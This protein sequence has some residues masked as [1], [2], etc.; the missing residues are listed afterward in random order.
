MSLKPLRGL[1]LTPLALLGGCHLVL[2]DPSGDVARQQS[3]IMVITTIIIALIIVPVLVAIGVVAWRY[4]A[5]NK[6]AKYDPN[7]DHSPQLELWV[8]AGPLLIIIAVGAVSWLG[9]HQTD[10]YR[11]LDRIA[12]G[13]PVPAG[14][15]PLEVDVVSLRWK[16][17]FLYPQYGIATVNELAAPVDRPIQFKLTADTMM[18]SFFVPA[19]VGQVYTMPGMQTILHGVINTPGEYKG[20]SANFSGAGFTDM[21]FKFHG[22]TAQDFDAWVGKVRAA[23]GD[24][25]LAAY[26]TLRKPTRNAPVQYFAK[27][28][29]DLYQRVLN[30]CAEPARVCK[31]QVMTAGTKDGEAM[32]GMH[33]HDAMPM[34]DAPQPSAPAAAH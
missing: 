12:P 11:A 15:K 31:N 30:L 20:F 27:F 22:L 10:P 23:G 17:L 6:Q 25:D 21:R 2:L 7:W 13:K 18:D 24:L 1:L 14:V 8:W 3:D 16:W 33:A 29:A 28:D 19:L 34:A 5:S 32:Q 9:T 26:D 4:R